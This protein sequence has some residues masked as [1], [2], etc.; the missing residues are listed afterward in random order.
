MSIVLS[1]FPVFMLKCLT[2]FTMK[3]RTWECLTYVATHH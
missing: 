3:P 2:Q 1:H